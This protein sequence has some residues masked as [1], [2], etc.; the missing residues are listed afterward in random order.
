MSDAC[1]Q[2]CLLGQVCPADATHAVELHWMST[3]LFYPDNGL[4]NWL[5]KVRLTRL[6]FRAA[7]QSSFRL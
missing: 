7:V 5:A 3:R 6:T 4:S 2:V 1:C